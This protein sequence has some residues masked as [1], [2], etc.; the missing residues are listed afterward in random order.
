[1]KHWEGLGTCERT[2]AQNTLTRAKAWQTRLQQVCSEVRA[3]VSR[4]VMHFKQMCSVHR[5]YSRQVTLKSPETACIT[6]RTSSFTHS[7]SAHSYEPGEPFQT[8]LMGKTF[9][10]S[11]INIYMVAR[12][13]GW[14]LDG[15]GG[16]WLN[17]LV[18][19]SSAYHIFVWQLCMRHLW[20]VP[21]IIIMNSDGR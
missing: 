12:N 17:M 16:Q 11:K 5:K 21:G 10:L 3:Q 20:K 6:E 18:K 7:S 19:W 13:Y 2:L 14:D 9:R 4:E 8:D 1:M 15:R